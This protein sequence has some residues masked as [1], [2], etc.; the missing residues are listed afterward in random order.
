MESDLLKLAIW[1]WDDIRLVPAA[2]GLSAQA[3]SG[4]GLGD[5]KHSKQIT[6]KQP[7]PRKYN[8]NVCF[9]KMSDVRFSGLASVAFPI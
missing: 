6:Q 8:Q 9:T 7:D 1:D 5:R 4:L 3:K 2:V